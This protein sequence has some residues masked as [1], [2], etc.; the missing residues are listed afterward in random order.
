MTYEEM[1]EHWRKHFEEHPPEP[2]TDWQI[3]ELR[4]AFNVDAPRIVGVHAALE[5]HE[6]SFARVTLEPWRLTRV[7]AAA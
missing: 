5:A 7:G 6:L 4:A 2:L 3:M 1:C